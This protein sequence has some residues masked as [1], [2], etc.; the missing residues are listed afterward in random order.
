MRTLLASSLALAIVSGGAWAQSPPAPPSPPSPGMKAPPGGPEVQGQGANARDDDVGGPPPPR[1][2]GRRPPPKAAHFRVELGDNVIDV[3]CGGRRAVEGLPGFYA[4]ITG[5]SSECFQT[6]KRK[7]P[8]KSRACKQRKRAFSST[9]DCGFNP[10][11]APPSSCEARL[12][13]WR[14]SGCRP[15]ASRSPSGPRSA[16]SGKLSRRA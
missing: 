4:Q 10:P 6:L 8:A 9:S 12:D 11:A 16:S 15:T 2:G 5:Q 14:T 7:G 13:P 1:P 3:S